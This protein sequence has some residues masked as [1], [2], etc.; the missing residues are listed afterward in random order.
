MFARAL[1]LHLRWFALFA[2]VAL[3]GVVLGQ[4]QSRDAGSLGDV[5]FWWNLSPT[6]LACLALG[7][8]VPWAVFMIDPRRSEPVTLAGMLRYWKAL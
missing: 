4:V 3:T 7:I 1:F 2:F 8:V 5:M 6:L